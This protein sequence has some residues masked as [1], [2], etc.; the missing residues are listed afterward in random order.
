MT[1]Q[2]LFS[3]SV[4]A[5]VKQGHKSCVGMACKYE[6]DDGSRCAIGHLLTKE[7]LVKLDGFEGDILKMMKEGR[8]PERLKCHIDMLIDLQ[9]AHDLT[10]QDSFLN[11]F[12]RNSSRVAMRYSYLEMPE[13]DLHAPTK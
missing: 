9:A 5:L 1:A 10:P 6:R 13:V 12:L 8:L 4:L 3:K 2:E 7:E 11:H